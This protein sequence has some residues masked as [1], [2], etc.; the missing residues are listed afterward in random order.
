MIEPLLAPGLLAIAFVAGVLTVLGP[1]SLPIVPL[2]VG[3]TGTGR[4][5]RVAGVLVGFATTF[6]LTAVAI[7]SVLAALG[8]TTQPLRALAALVFIV[9]G[10][11]LLWPSGAA[12]LARHLPSGGARPRALGSRGD[13]VAG[14]AFGAGIGVL[15][16]PC[17]GPLMAGVIAAAA[18]EGPSPSGVAIAAAYVVGAT[19]PLA[20]LAIGG[21]SLASRLGSA[22]RSLR[23]RQG[24]GMLMVI[25]GLLVISGL[26]LRLQSAVAATSAD[27][28]QAAMTSTAG[29]ADGG[30]SGA[31]PGSPDAGGS[32]ASNGP[33]LVVPLEDLGPAPE[34][35]GITAWINSDPL[36]MA[37]LRGKVVLV[38]F[39]TFACINCI[40]V[41]PYV[42]A[43]YDEYRDDGFVVVGIHTPELSFERDL[44]NVRQAVADDGVTFPVGFDPRFDTWH[45]YQNRFWPG[46]WFVDREGIIRHVHY[47][48]GDY[49][50]SE[51]VIRELLAES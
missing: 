35:K 25:A 34:F 28:E 9:A 33:G 31:G 2:V 19:V 37:S 46:F 38:H 29:S 23:L 11:L 13:L 27:L 5:V 41:Q 49:A 40:H 39:W 22:T 50:A 6:L 3:V 14:L 36:K 15:W 12:W 20:A 21:R 42:K 1:C 45:A 26:D 30:S 10:G 51:A 32:A 16:A 18:V 4:V 24:Y 48:E 47:G 43:W 44:D 8:L 7:A 17:V